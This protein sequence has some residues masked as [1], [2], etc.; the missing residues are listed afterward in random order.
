VKQYG[1]PR[2]IHIV[3]GLDDPAEAKRIFQALSEGGTVQMPLRKTFWAVRFG[4]LVD[5]FGI[6]NPQ[7]V[8]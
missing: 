4:M 6:S 5:P 3:L 7:T 1:S 2:G 8:A